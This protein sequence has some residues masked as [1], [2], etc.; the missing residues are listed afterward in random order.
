MA[1]T[2]ITRKIGIGLISLIIFY[3]IGYFL[4]LDFIV[5]YLWFESMGYSG[6]FWVRI[7]YQYGIPFIATILFFLIFYIHFWIASIYLGTE[8]SHADKETKSLAHK[9]KTGA[10]EIYTPLSVV[11]AVLMVIPLFQDWQSTLLF[12]FGPESGVRENIY[13]NDISFY[14][15]SL[16]IFR[17]IQFE[18][19]MTAVIVFVSVSFLYFLEQRLLSSRGKHLPVGATVH[20]IILIGFVCAW[21]VWGFLL[22]RFNLLHSNAH[23]PLFYGPGWVEMNIELNLIWIAV[24]SFIVTSYAAIM[25]VMTDG[26]RGKWPLFISLGF[27]GLSF[28]LRMIPAI[29]KFIDDYIVVPNQFALEKKYIDSNIKATLHGYKLDHTKQ[30]SIPL[31][32]SS[33]DDLVVGLKKEFSHNIPLWD[34]QYL[35]D[36]YNQLQAITP[37]FHFFNIDEDR[38]LMDGYLHQ[39]NLGAREIDL[40]KL[41]VSSHTWQN[42]HLRYTHGYGYAMSPAAQQADIPMQWYVR[43]ITMNSSV[44]LSTK[45]PDIYYGESN[46]P[47]VI[48][49]NDLDI[50]GIP[51]SDDQDTS[52][53]IHLGEGGIHIGSVWRKLVFA[54]YFGD[55]LIFMSADLNPTS[56]LRM[57]R[58]IKDRIYALAPELVLDEDPYLVSG[59]DYLYWVQDAYTFSDQYPIS[60]PS[61]TL[62]H[63]AEGA[64]Q[65]RFNY[66]RNSV[67]IIINAYDGV[68]RFYVSDPTDPIIKAYQRAYQ[69]IFKPLSEMPGELK[70]H[71]R[72]PEDFFKYQ[73][74]IFA[75]YHQTDPSVFYQQ[76]ETWSLAKIGDQK[77]PPYYLTTSLEL[78]ECRG[79]TQFLHIG[80]M[81][82]VNRNNLSGLLI[83]GTQNPETCANNHLTQN[84]TSLEVPTQLQVNGPAQ[85]DA[86]IHQDPTISANFTLWN[87]QGSTVKLG[88]MIILPVSNTMVYIQPVYLLAEKNTIPQ[89]ARIIVSASDEVVM[90]VSLEKA[91]DKLLQKLKSQKS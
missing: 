68:V 70:S 80:V 22:Q 15:F 35:D 23:E 56:K 21:V 5:E 73:L 34:T 81:T 10:M 24:I 9:F 19:L 61:V 13:G 46:Y 67:K 26:K 91:F 77:M 49:P 71:L 69:G 79:I 60:K 39:V 47:Y 54:V 74:K 27:L 64:E 57:R 66:V 4:I 58:N 88:H 32:S 85:V 50:I 2:S 6:Y 78:P 7:F 29:P 72:Y 48:V 76:A 20:R 65:R 43:D 40:K 87:Q 86:L 41:P 55:P 30:V 37:Y 8:L 90:D 1:K 38:Y 36:V 28:L 31:N 51:S 83:G 18:L 82:W 3:V 62:I 44:G 33:Y 84:L 59:K 63:T 16:P 12:L 89:L 17:I 53:H 45:H 25:L 52:K 75:R 42:I 11:L 14:L